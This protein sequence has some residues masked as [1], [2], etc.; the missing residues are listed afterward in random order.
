MVNKVSS[1][2][3]KLINLEEETPISSPENI[4]FKYSPQN[5]PKQYFE[6]SP[7]KGSPSID[8]MQQQ[9]YD[10][11]ESMENKTTPMDLGCSTNL[12]KLVNQ[13]EPLTDSLKQEIYELE[14]LDM[15]I[16]K[17]N[18]ILK[19]QTKLDKA[20]HDNTMLHLAIWYKKNRNLNKKSSTLNID[21]S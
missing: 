4:P 16:K 19:E 14:I 15:H 5:S 8:P 6:G 9:I 18:E 13:Q 12:E 3:T 21:F 17:E 7:N 20:I 10:Y 1:K 11:I 2:E